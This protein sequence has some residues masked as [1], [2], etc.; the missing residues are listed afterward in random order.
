MKGKTNTQTQKSIRK[1]DENTPLNAA[2]N[3][4]TFSHTNS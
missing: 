1:Y 3:A 2:K 4:L